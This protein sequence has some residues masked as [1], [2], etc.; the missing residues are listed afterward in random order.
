[1]HLSLSLSLGSPMGGVGRGPVPFVDLDFANQ[2]YVLDGSVEPFSEFS[3]VDISSRLSEDGLSF[4][5]V[6]GDVVQFLSGFSGTL[7]ANGVMTMWVEVAETSVAEITVIASMNA[8]SGPTANQFRLSRRANNDPTENLRGVLELTSNAA[9]VTQTPLRQNPTVVSGQTQW[10][11]F[12]VGPDNFRLQ[13]AGGAERVDSSG[14]SVPTGPFI[15][16]LGGGAGS[17]RPM[18]GMIKRVKIFRED[19]PAPIGLIQALQIQTI[20]GVDYKAETPAQ[21]H[22]INF[23]G[24]SSANPV[25]MEVRAGEYWADTETGR[26]RNEFAQFTNLTHGTT[27]R[28]SYSFMPINLELPADGSEYLLTG[29]LHGSTIGDGRSPI[30]GFDWEPNGTCV[31]NGRYVP[32]EGGSTTDVCSA[33]VVLPLGE[34]TDVE[35]EYKAHATDGI[36]K[37]WIGGS[38]VLDYSGPIGFLD[39][40]TDGYWKFGYYRPLATETGV[41]RYADMQLAPL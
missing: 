34:Y 26:T 18:T 6:S 37:A 17:V 21:P 12:A 11:R 2:R 13:D 1:M 38:L 32:A 24:K 41:V 30:F 29:Q 7:M 36:L 33:T 35:I 15:L 16:V 5:G 10:L 39:D 27:Y 9:S 14:L 3:S 20:N 40:A 28:I 23:A 31:L 25:T 19:V 8:A 4:T 22:S